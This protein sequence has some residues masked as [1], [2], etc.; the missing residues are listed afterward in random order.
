MDY[1]IYELEIRPVY[2]HQVTKL[3]GVFLDLNEVD[4]TDTLS[5]D[6]EMSR[7]PVATWYLNRVGFIGK[8]R[9]EYHVIR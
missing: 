9:A 2:G 7:K 1:I 5:A 8:A 3:S 6:D 4:I